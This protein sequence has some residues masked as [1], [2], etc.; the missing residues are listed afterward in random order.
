MTCI[1]LLQMTEIIF[2][3]SLI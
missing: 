1:P 3:W 2:R